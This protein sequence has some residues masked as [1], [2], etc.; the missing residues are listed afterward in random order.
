ML[1]QRVITALALLAI[2]VSIL[3]LLPANYAIAA[4]A[5]IAVLAA[6]E[7]SRLLAADK[8]TRLLFPLWVL[9]C[10]GLSLWF[11]PLQLWLCVLAAV[12]WLLVPFWFSRRWP[13]SAGIAGILVGTIVLVPA[14]VGMVRLHGIGPWALL[15]AMALVWVADIAAY[16]V[17]R[18]IGRHKLAPA[19]SP[20][21]TW[22][23]AA[24]A[25]IGGLLYAFVLRQY[26]GLSIPVNTAWFVFGTVLLVGISIVGDLFESMI[27]R[28]AGVKDSSRLL[29]GHGGVLDRIDSLTSTLPVLVVASSIWRT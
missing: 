18:A 20:G 3:F 8:P 16:F 14:W 26:G 9:A 27:K 4:F 2:L 10:C 24:G 5:L 28:Q 1:K 12:F 11:P 21:K 23:G 19:I 25:A 13:L 29:P 22:E 6:W 7:W 15:S 17:G